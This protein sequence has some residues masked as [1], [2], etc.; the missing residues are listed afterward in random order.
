MHGLHVRT[1]VVVG[2][3]LGREFVKMIQTLLLTLA[4]ALP[5]KL[6][7]AMRYHVQVAIVSMTIIVQ[8][9]ISLVL[10]F[11]IY[12]FICSCIYIRLYL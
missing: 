6:A 12:V 5:A 8:M 3:K 4:L 1:H 7:H 2:F 9:T 11:T 10:D